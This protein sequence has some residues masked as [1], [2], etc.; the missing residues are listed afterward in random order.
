M[1]KEWE[2]I[3]GIALIIGVIVFARYFE[4]KSEK[5]CTCYEVVGDESNYAC[6]IPSGELDTKGECVGSKIY[7]D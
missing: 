7:N 6:Y 5:S 3:L 4:L 1:K 2:I